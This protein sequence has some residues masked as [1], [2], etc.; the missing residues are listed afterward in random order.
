MADANP[1]SKANYVPS[2]AGGRLATLER[3]NAAQAAQKDEQLAQQ[4]AQLAE[5]AAT[6]TAQAATIAEQAAQLEQQTEQLAQKGATITQQ[7]AR[8]AELGDS[9]TFSALLAGGPHGDASDASSRHAAMAAVTRPVMSCTGLTKRHH[10]RP[11]PQRTRSRCTPLRI[12]AMG[13]RVE[14]KRA[15]AQSLHCRSRRNLPTSSMETVRL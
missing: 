15:A 12:L 13:L 11:P 2:G 10:A 7:V 3:E 6:S 8:I 5:Q 1:F 4:A 14:T 9:A